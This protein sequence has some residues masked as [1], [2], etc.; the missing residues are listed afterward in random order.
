[1]IIAFD[2][3]TW[4]TVMIWG[5]TLKT[6][7]TS[8]NILI[9]WVLNTKVISIFKFL[10]LY[11]SLPYSVKRIFVR[12]YSKLAGVDLVFPIVTRKIRITIPA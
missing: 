11:I 12:L 8:F 2:I 4:R 5:D 6:V 7:K 9:V 3:N 1:M 10:T